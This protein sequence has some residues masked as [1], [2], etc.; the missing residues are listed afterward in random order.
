MFG[1]AIGLVIAFNVVIVTITFG[2]SCDVAC[3]PN[4]SITFD[5]MVSPFPFFS[6]SLILHNF[7]IDDL[8]SLH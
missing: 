4:V 3:V 2:A 7:A 5:E 8:P 1:V 6:L